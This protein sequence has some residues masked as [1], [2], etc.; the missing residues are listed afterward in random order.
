MCSPYFRELSRIFEIS[1]YQEDL[2]SGVLVDLYYYTI[3]FCR[4]NNFT[5]EQTSAL[6]SIIKKTHEICV[7]RW[8]SVMYSYLFQFKLVCEKC[9]LHVIS[10]RRLTRAGSLDS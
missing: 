6:F 4:E 1:D 7:G 2:K 9:E 5:Q 8:Y 3:Q 10:R